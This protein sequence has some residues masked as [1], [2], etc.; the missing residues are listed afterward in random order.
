MTSGRPFSKFNYDERFSTRLERHLAL[1]NEDG[2][3]IE[4]CESC[5]FSVKLCVCSGRNEPI[6]KLP[7]PKSCR[8]KWIF[9]IVLGLILIGIGLYIFNI[10]RRNRRFNKREYCDGVER[11]PMILPPSLDP[12]TS[13]TRSSPSTNP[14][15]SP[16]NAFKFGK[17]N[18]IGFDLNKL[19]PGDLILTRHIKAN[20]KDDELS[21]MR[22]YF[23]DCNID[24]AWSTPG[25]FKNVK[26]NAD[27]EGIIQAFTGCDLPSHTILVAKVYRP[28]GTNQD[29]LPENVEL[30][31]FTR[32][33]LR[34][35]MN[36]KE[37]L[38]DHPC[39]RKQIWVM[40][41]N[42][43]ADDA[44]LSMSDAY[45]DNVSPAR[46]KVSTYVGFAARQRRGLSM[47][48]RQAFYQSLVYNL[49]SETDT[50]K[51]KWCQ[52]ESVE[53]DISHKIITNPKT[54]KHVYSYFVNHNNCE[55]VCVG[56]NGRQLVKSCAADDKP[57][58][59][60]TGSG[61]LDLQDCPLLDDEEEDASSHYNDWK[62]WKGLDH[63]TFSCSSIAYAMLE[64]C[65]LTLPMS[66]QPTFRKHTRRVPSNRN[67]MRKV[68]LDCILHDEMFDRSDLESG[69]K[70]DASKDISAKLRIIAPQ[71][72]A[73]CDYLRGDFQWNRGV[74]VEYASRVFFTFD[75]Q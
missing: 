5:K 40:H 35:R 18:T 54:S 17:L 16:S 28:Y 42:K 51:S 55:D 9:F 48:S 73:P 33:N 65:G 10:F 12:L 68:C 3:Y 30:W 37:F 38:A 20:E 64:S 8:K 13:Y 58:F 70:S 47:L 62:N 1:Y 41:L 59:I 11:S 29:V 34:R 72:I 44:T 74:Y 6:K 43:S 24:R 45:I 50:N 52:C 53:S 19:K 46:F 61:D 27:V 69:W 39:T 49:Y 36:L 7:K 32:S 56:G 60:H 14:Q 2:E 26:Q 63:Q 57:F 75:E 71:H 15:Y 25:F 21:R 23:P 31:D 22:E 4:Y 66:D 67:S